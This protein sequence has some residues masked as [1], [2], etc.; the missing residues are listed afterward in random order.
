MKRG[1]KTVAEI[2]ATGGAA[3]LISSDLH[4]AA[5]VR[6]VAKRAVFKSISRAR[7]NLL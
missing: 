4:N 2:R 1:E 3:D 6:E 7:C 5:S